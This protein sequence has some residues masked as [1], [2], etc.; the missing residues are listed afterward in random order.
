M[1]SAP[2]HSELRDPK[3]HACLNKKHFGTYAAYKGGLSFK[4][5]P[6]YKVFYEDAQSLQLD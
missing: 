1:K 5:T 4:I 2:V 6:L 3:K